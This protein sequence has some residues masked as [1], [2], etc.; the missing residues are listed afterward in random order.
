MEKR[1]Q[2]MLRLHELPELM[3]T[4]NLDIMSHEPLVSG[5][6]LNAVRALP[7]EKSFW[8]CVS[9]RRVGASAQALAH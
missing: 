1:A 8:A 6:Y 4:W 3:H 9:H 5:S 7:D 2:S